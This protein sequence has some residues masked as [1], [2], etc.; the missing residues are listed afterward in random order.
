MKAITKINGIVVIHPHS[1]KVTRSI[2]KTAIKNYFKGE[3]IPT[4]GTVFMEDIN[5]QIFVRNYSPTQSEK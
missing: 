5:Y 4:F 1:G 3:K 2:A